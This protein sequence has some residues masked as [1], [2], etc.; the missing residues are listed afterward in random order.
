MKSWAEL[1]Q[2]ESQAD[3]VLNLAVLLAYETRKDRWRDVAQFYDA[4]V[5]SSSPGKERT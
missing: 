1:M 5:E 2:C 4:L 3:A